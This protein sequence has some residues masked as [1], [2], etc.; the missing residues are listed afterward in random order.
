MSVAVAR[1]PQF[2]GANQAK[3]V[4]HEWF[5]TREPYRNAFLK[6]YGWDDAAV[7]PMR[8]DMGARR[9][10]RLTRA[11]G[12]TRVLMESVPDGHEYATPGQRLD[13]YVLIAEMLRGQGL[14]APR[15][16]A[17]DYSTGYVLLED[18]GDL[19]FRSA[20]LSGQVA[21]PEIYGAA[22]DVLKIL[23]G[24]S[25]P[26]SVARD[27][28]Y[29]GAM[30]KGLR[31]MI[32]WYVPVKRG[33]ANEPG[34]VD[35]FLTR[36]KTVEETARAEVG[37]PVQG[38]VH[39][40]FHLENL[41]WRG[42]QTGVSCAGILD[43]QDARPGPAVYDLTNLLNDARMTLPAGEKR[44][45]LAEFL[46][47]VRPEHRAN[48]ERWFWI[49]SAQFLHRVAGQFI[50]HATIGNTRYLQFMPFIQAN[51]KDIFTHDFLAPVGDFMMQ[52]GV[53]LEPF[54]PNLDFAAQVPLIAKDA[55]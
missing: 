39:C 47:G 27:T 22:M 49:Y 29:D 45:Y 9:Y 11:S 12:E 32:D 17:Y 54:A 1:Q 3:S 37:E 26:A 10:F 6:Q 15:V 51:L 7:T 24:F 53:D 14:S 42:D 4:L 20:M 5:A 8:E 55:Y 31:R 23:S 46:A 16:D 38:F 34:L 19:S 41:Q 36:W 43:F 52:L 28:Y 2:A 25:W 33:K 48:F 30:Y 50:K 18:F 21:R 13:D 35:E 44:A 40:D